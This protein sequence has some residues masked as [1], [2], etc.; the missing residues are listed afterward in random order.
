MII[1]CYSDYLR[2]TR[3]SKESTIKHYIQALS[4]INRILSESDLP[5]QNV[6]SITCA[7]DLEL[8]K[9]Y[10][11]SNE[12]YIT[13]NRVGN[14]MYSAAFNHYCSFVNDEA[15]FNSYRITKLDNPIW[16]D[17]KSR[18]ISS[19]II[20]ELAIRAE[21]YKCT[22]DRTHQSFESRYTSQPYMIGHHLIPLKFQNYFLVSLDVYANIVALC[23]IC[24]SKIHYG[25]CTDRTQM[26]EGL[27]DLRK[28]R[29]KTAGINVTLSDILEFNGCV[30]DLS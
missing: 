18:Q 23:P 17:D 13:K 25:K 9:V 5:I 19:P 27:F 14:N 22:V 2:V 24:K 1:G 28:T 10:L 30:G 7:K 21:D 16:T 15:Y 3:G 11:N 12:K 26:L 4:T 29:L 6:Y 20:T 8:I